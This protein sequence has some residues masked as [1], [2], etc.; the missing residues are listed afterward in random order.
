MAQ[1]ATTGVEQ[2]QRMLIAAPI[3]NR[4]SRRKLSSENRPPI[5]ASNIVNPTGYNNDGKSF[6]RKSE[7][8][9][10]NINVGWA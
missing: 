5:R 10:S 7:K 6:D 1:W 2:I 8:P 9:L 3:H 4:A